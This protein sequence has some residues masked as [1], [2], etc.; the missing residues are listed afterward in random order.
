M[1]CPRMSG[2]V[3]QEA[4]ALLTMRQYLVA[5]KIGLE[6]NITGSLKPF[7]LITQRGHACAKTFRERVMTILC[8]AD[9]RGITVREAVTPLL[10]VYDSLCQQLAIMTQKVTA[11]AKANPICKRMMTAP[12]VGPIVAL[13]FVTAVDNPRRFKV[14]SDVGAYFGLTPQQY[15]SGN[16]YIMGNTSRRGDIMTRCHLVQAATSLLAGTKKWCALKACGVK[17]AKKHGFSK[18]RIAVARKLSIILC[19]M[20]INE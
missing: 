8:R 5:Q 11:L 16:T 4:R 7:G 13:S 10:D 2:Q 14:S 6:N 12:G 20:W 19:R 15:Q 17:L 3:N 18:A 9:E 1:A